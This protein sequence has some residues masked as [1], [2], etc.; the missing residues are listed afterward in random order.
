MVLHAGGRSDNSVDRIKI[1]SEINRVIAEYCSVNSNLDLELWI[2]KLLISLYKNEEYKDEL[3][4]TFRYRDTF[5]VYVKNLNCLNLTKVQ[6]DSSVYEVTLHLSEFFEKWY[7][8]KKSLNEIRELIR[9]TES[10]FELLAIQIT[11]VIEEWNE[12]AEFM[13]SMERTENIESDN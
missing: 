6:G 12:D 9:L 2:K 7:G 11:Q 4:H 10:D 5:L 3:E 13:E 8:L 1:A